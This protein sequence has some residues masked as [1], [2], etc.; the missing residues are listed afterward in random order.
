MLK[1]IKYAKLGTTNAS[2]QCRS[3]RSNLICIYE[4]RVF[5]LFKKKSKLKRCNSRH[6]RGRAS[7]QIPY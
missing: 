4:N 6:R 1:D 7:M 2:P 3:Y 5:P